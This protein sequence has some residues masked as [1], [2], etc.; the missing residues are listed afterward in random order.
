MIS[1]GGGVVREVGVLRG[2]GSLLAFTAKYA[3]STNQ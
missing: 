3:V 1:A 2:E